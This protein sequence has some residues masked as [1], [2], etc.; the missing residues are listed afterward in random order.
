V[1]LEEN[2]W[3]V[4]C[5][6]CEQPSTMPLDNWNRNMETASGVLKARRDAFGFAL[7]LFEIIVGERLRGVSDVWEE[8]RE[9]FSVAS[10]EIQLTI[11]VPVF[12]WKFISIRP[13]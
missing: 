9:C 2:Q 8:L 7:I 5:V 12:C 3:C 11:W 1:S 10:H 4:M 6:K 13:I